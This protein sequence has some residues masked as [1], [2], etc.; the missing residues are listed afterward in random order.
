[1]PFGGIRAKRRTFGRE[2]RQ[3]LQPLCQTPLPHSLAQFF[4]KHAHCRDGWRWGA[5]RLVQAGAQVVGQGAEGRMVEHGRGRQADAGGGRQPT[6]QLDGREGIE[7]Q[8]KELG[9]SRYRRWIGM[10]KHL[11]D[12]LGNHRQQACPPLGGS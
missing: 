8:D 6:A 5:L 12:P 4:E 7:T 11:T 10:L 2:L 9:I 3:S 1:M